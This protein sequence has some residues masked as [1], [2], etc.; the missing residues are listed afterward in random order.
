MDP[1]VKHASGLPRLTISNARHIVVSL[2]I[3]IGLAGATTAGV[4]P[5]TTANDVDELESPAAARESDL[6]AVADGNGWT[7]AQAR[8]Q[9]EVW[10]EVARINRQ[11]AA[12]RRDIYIGAAL[13]D[14]PG[15]TPSLYIKG[16]APKWVRDLV[17]DTKVHIKIVDKQPYSFD[18][19]EQRKMKVHGALVDM[20]YKE[21]ATGINITGAGR[22]GPVVLKTPGLPADRA[23]I[24]EGVP[25]DLRSSVDVR[26]TDT[27][28]GDG[29]H[30]TGGMK[31]WSTYDP[32]AFCT[33]GFSVEH[34]STGAKSVVSA[35]HCGVP[36]HPNQHVNRIEAGVAH[37]MTSSS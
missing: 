15:G 28:Y 33:S 19:L 12:E 29:D 11:V 10:Q 18:E 34:E 4:A 13:S 9:I 6:K 27:S 17:A 36:G 21:V 37:V 14:E 23:S 35:G 26:V 5:T 8:A 20:G 22:V 1:A 32:P 3:A 2:L 31:T 25:A 30:A 7:V 24:L 16:L